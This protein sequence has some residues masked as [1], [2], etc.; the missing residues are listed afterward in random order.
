MA[1]DWAGYRTRRGSARARQGF[2]TRPFPARAWDELHNSP[3]VHMPWPYSNAEADGIRA[4]LPDGFRDGAFETV[5]LAARKY[6]HAQT[7][8]RPGKPNPRR[9]IERL[10]SALV[11]LCDAVMGLTPEAHEYL[12]AKSRPAHRAGQQ[13]FTAMSLRLAIDK[14]DHENRWALDHPPRP[15]RGGPAARN[16]EAWLVWRLQGAFSVAHGGKRPKRGWPEF[17]KLCIAP[18][19]DFG[20]P[21]RSDKAWQDVLRKR[22]NNLRKK[23]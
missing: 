9:E 5:V 6:V 20:L 11:R 12:L 13:P 22:R 16:H 17:L 10:R 2:K 8:I 19:Q 1:L 3:A 15:E 4:V 7:L 23:G 14:F 21:M 18:L